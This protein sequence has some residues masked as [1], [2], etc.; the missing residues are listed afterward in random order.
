[1][2]I[3]ASN[4]PQPR[5]LEFSHEGAEN[6]NWNYVDQHVLGYQEFAELP[7]VRETKI[8]AKVLAS[9]KRLCMAKHGFHVLLIFVDFKVPEV[10]LSLS[11][12][13]NRSTPLWKTEL[14]GVST[15]SS[16][17]FWI[18]EADGLFKPHQKTFHHATTS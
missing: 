10:S 16:T 3:I 6:F 13:A 5:K 18:C 1:M 4:Y 9:A 17:Y 2:L 8:L 12:S 14:K 11:A 15:A 7:E